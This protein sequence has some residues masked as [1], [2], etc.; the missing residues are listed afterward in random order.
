MT[1]YTC[2]CCK[3]TTSIKGNYTRHL[4]TNIHI[5][6]MNE[7]KKQKENNEQ[8]EKETENENK[9]ETKKETQEEREIESQNISSTK[10]V[11]NEDMNNKLEHKINFDK[12]DKSYVYNIY[13]SKDNE[14]Y[15]MN[16]IKYRMKRV[17]HIFEP[18]EE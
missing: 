13:D 18:L 10:I 6:K 4:S 8:K 17:I 2:E 14:I 1:I 5:E 12:I 9:N 16:G 7:I 11:I 3:Y 15:M